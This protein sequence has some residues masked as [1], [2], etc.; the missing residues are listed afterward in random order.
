MDAKTKLMYKKE[1]LVDYCKKNPRYKYRAI[2]SYIARRRKEDPSLTDEQIIEEYFATE[3]KVNSRYY[4]NGMTIPR[5]CELKGKS[6]DALYQR[7]SRAR[8]DPRNANKSKEEIEQDIIAKYFCEA[9]VELV[10]ED[11]FGLVLKKSE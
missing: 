10:F 11:N 4:I 6:E 7:I 3:H 9:T 8:K 5:Y 1:A 2:T